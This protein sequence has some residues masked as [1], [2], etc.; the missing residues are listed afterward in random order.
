MSNPAAAAAFAAV[1]LKLSPFLRAFIELAV[2]V[3]LFSFSN[4]T[5]R[6][7]NIFKSLL[8]VFKCLCLRHS[9]ASS[10][11]LSQEKREEKTQSLSYMYI[12]VVRPMLFCY[13]NLVTFIAFH[14]CYVKTLLFYGCYC[15]WFLTIFQ[16][17]HYRT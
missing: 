12:Y 14:F 16:R 3:A 4:S 5:Q 8:H 2:N 7:L 1:C 10:I 13:N 15:C 6:L 17:I 9:F 11:N